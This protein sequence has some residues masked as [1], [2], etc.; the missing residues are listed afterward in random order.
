MAGRVNNHNYKQY[1]CQSIIRCVNQS[2]DSEIFMSNPCVITVLVVCRLL[3]NQDDWL[4]SIQCQLVLTSFP[5]KKI[6]LIDILHN[7]HY[8][9]LTLYKF[10]C[11]LNK[12]PE[13]VM[14]CTIK[15]QLSNIIPTSH[16]ICSR[17]N[18]QEWMNELMKKCIS[19]LNKQ[20]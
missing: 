18:N 7:F 17:T 6:D 1:V 13:K 12:W 14:C 11:V 5:L 2:S 15:Q 20:F 16:P 3:P 19:N 9:I 10:A 4:H 8:F